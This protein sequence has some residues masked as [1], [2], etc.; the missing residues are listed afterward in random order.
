MLAY[1][2]LKGY[3][4]TDYLDPAH[5]VQVDIRET[6]G[7]MLGV[8]VVLVCAPAALQLPPLPLPLLRI[9]RRLLRPWD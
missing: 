3:P 8:P 5:P 7:E 6:L 9:E 1:A 2:R 4:L